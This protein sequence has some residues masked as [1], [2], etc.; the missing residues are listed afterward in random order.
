MVKT[1]IRGLSYKVTKEIFYRISGQTIKVHNFEQQVDV[2]GP[3][4][5][6]LQDAIVTGFMLG[7]AFTLTVVAVTL[8][9]V[10]HN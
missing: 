9:V 1:Y 8:I 7:S 3:I 2:F 10:F 4:M 5:K 6:A